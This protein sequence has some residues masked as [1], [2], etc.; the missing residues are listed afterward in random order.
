MVRNGETVYLLPG[1]LDRKRM[2]IHIEVIDELGGRFLGV[3]PMHVGLL[4]AISNLIERH[5]IDDLKL[6]EWI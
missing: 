3:A 1:L 5:W 6:M 2:R 4:Y